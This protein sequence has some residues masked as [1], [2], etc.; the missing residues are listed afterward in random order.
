MIK[1]KMLVFVL[2]S[3]LSSNLLLGQTQKQTKSML[4]GSTKVVV[5]NCSGDCKLN[6]SLSNEIALDAV[7]TAHGTVYGWKKISTP[8]LEILTEQHNDTLFISS[9]PVNL[10][11][12][13]GISTYYETLEMHITLPSSIN[14]VRV[15]CEKT[16]HAA[17]MKQNI[18]SIYCTASDELW[19][20]GIEKKKEYE[21]GGVG[22]Q[23]FVFKGENIRATMK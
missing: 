9:T 22:T 13:I 5:I 19:F 3:L 10:V 23:K 4:P 7:L 14:E 17:V 21:F 12:T 1:R 11:S 2:L 15:T 20:N 6:T 8:P 16:L 18:A